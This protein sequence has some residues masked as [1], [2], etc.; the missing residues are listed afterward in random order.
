MHCLPDELVRRLDETGGP[1]RAQYALTE[2]IAYYQIQHEDRQQ[3]EWQQALER[4]Q[5][6][7]K[8]F[9]RKR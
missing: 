2:L 1:L 7:G 3:R 6:D 5:R 8:S 9:G 4:K